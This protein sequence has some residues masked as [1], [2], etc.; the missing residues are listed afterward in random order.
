MK[1]TRNTTGIIIAVICA[2]LWCAFADAAT[3]TDLQML[4]RYRELERAAEQKLE[5]SKQEPNA[6]ML[7]YLCVAYSKL[8]RYNKLFDCLDKLEKRIR[9]GDYVLETDKIFVANSDG[10]PLPNM[11]RAEALIELGQYKEAVREANAALGKVQDR[12]TTGIWPPKTY[13]LSLMGTLGLAYALDGDTKNAR[14]QIEKLDNFSL[15]F[16]GIAFTTT[17]RANSLARINMALGQYNKAFEYVKDEENILV[18]SVWFVNNVAWGYS[19]DDAVETVYLTLPKLLIR[20]KCLSELGNLEEAGKTFDVMLRN[21]RIADNGE[22]YWLTLFERGRVAEKQGRIAEAIDLYRRAVDV[23][24]SQRSTINTEANKIGFV[25]DKQ[26][27]YRRLIASLHSSG[28]Y[29]AAF[30]YVERSKSRALVDLLAEKKDFSVAGGDSEKVIELLNL[31]KKEEQEAVSQDLSPSSSQNRTR[32]MKTKEQIRG[33]SP[34]LA[35]LISVTSIPLA[36]L[37]RLIGA[38]ETLIE[39]YY[40][41][42]DIYIFFL[43]NGKLRSVR[44][45]KGAIADDIRLLRS[46]IENPR[47]GDTIALCQRLYKQIVAPIESG[48]KGQSL[49]IVPHGA[50]HYLP[51]NAL[52][53]GRSYLIERHSIRM[54]PSA[55]VSKYL[56]AR[57]SPDR[58]D[59]FAFG[60]PDL[61]DPAYDLKYAQNEAI[62]VAATRPRSMVLLREKATE[63]ALRKFGIGFNY[64]HFATHGQFD[65]DAPLQSALL[66]AGDGQS[67]GKLTVDKLYSMRLEADLVT[68]SA[69]ETGLGKVASGDDVVGLTRGFLYAGSSTVVA[70]LWKVDD[71]ATSY[72]MT[73]FYN[74]LK[75]THKQDALRRAQLK[76]KEKYGHPFFWAAFELTGSAR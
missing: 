22:I 48:L 9:S 47:S 2:V 67:D 5:A 62:A 25:G 49:I 34:E 30:D 41:D 68:L 40:D 10:T 19:G 45:M 66:L 28:Q 61:G 71:M 59:I 60:N 74:A 17:F 39:Y 58:P 12:M 56:Q 53:D 26:D 69:C 18:R 23:I 35:S 6:S 65:S 76:S 29:E 4:G 42:K 46:L 33:Q 13:R 64:I 31:I 54:L 16:I 37:Q 3:L 70:S 50:L 36:E 55:S 32:S 44:V 15:G 14:A 51:F 72:L 57:K 7:G 24:E 20:G 27:V 1:T 38:D 75:V 73:E 52:H 21:A 63:T 43:S 8:K 11:L